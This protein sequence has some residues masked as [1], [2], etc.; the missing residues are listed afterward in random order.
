MKRI[1]LVGDSDIAYWPKELFP[2]PWEGGNDC[3][4]EWDQ[5]LVSGHSGATLAE[6]VPHLR[7]IIEESRTLRHSNTA[8]NAESRSQTSSSDAL[9]VVACAGEN[10]I[11]EGLS[12][13]K[14]LDAMQK[15]LDLVFLAEDGIGNNSTVSSQTT[16]HDRYLV[17]LGP[18]FEPWLQ[19]DPSYKKKYEAM[20][21]AF[22]HCL[23]D[24]SELDGNSA[25]G[26]IRFVDCLT[27]FCGETANVPGARLCGRAEADPR[28]FAS[29]QL[30]L[31][32][33]G[34]S[35]WKD[36]VESQIRGLLSRSKQSRT[37]TM[38]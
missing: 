19:H 4:T 32:S 12:L 26:R 24:Y 37:P 17:F 31:N 7:T 2:T 15:F 14:S 27:M 36:V 28:Y 1:L 33:Q 5:T 21:R 10:D 34:Y 30:H 13:G 9:V 8:S 6:V 29:D 11:G 3:D 23:Q 38:G 18:K 35:M 25:H 20:A 16:T 22:R